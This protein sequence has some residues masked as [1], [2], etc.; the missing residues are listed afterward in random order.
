MTA[1][2]VYLPTRKRTPIVGIG[3]IV[4]HSDDACAGAD[5]SRSEKGDISLVFEG[6]PRGAKVAVYWDFE[7][8]LISQ[9]KYVHGK[10]A[11]DVDD[12]SAQ[13]RK[14]RES[15]IDTSVVLRYAATLG[16]VAVNRAYCDWTRPLFRSYGAELAKVGGEPVQ[17]FAATAAKNGAD[18]RM[19]LDIAEDLTFDA[20]VTDVLI[21]SGDSDFLAL[22]EHV[23]RGGRR[24][25]AIGVEGSTNG[26]WAKAC[27]F[28]EYNE[29]VNLGSVVA[30]SPSPVAAD[31]LL[32]V[33]RRLPDGQWLPTDAVACLLQRGNWAA[34]PTTPDIDGVIAAALADGLIESAGSAH[35]ARIR[36]AAAAE[37][38][39][40]LP[41]E[42]EL[43][44]E[45][46]AVPDVPVTVR[47][48][49]WPKV[50]RAA[51]RVHPLAVSAAVHAR[52][53]WETW[54]YRTRV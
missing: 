14:A 44:D 5:P 32:A 48:G 13:L 49:R 51:R 22:V 42:I 43:P 36:M 10:Q 7:N 16:T 45:V 15:P 33:L 52:K 9:Y 18:I 3:D 40:E 26:V 25:H 28:R 41:D 8:L 11:W 53:R 29:L 12:F 37:V 30:R 54:W 21:C 50:E 4:E 31:E 27:D 20:D 23:H 39:E 34:D 38:V 47:V 24:I 1:G 35:S 2:I 17:Q 6:V 46:E 19:A